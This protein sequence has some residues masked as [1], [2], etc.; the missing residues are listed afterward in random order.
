MS[1]LRI[2]GGRRLEGTL[3]VHGAKNSVLPI[4]A[5]SILA[6]GETIIHNCPDL[7][8]VNAAIKILRHLGCSVDKSNDRVIINSAQMTRS[9]IPHELMK[10]MR[11][12]VIFLGAILARCGTAA[13]SMPGGCE[14]GPR[15]VD[16][17]MM[18][19]REMGAKITDEGGS[20]LC[21]A[22]ELLGCRINFPIPSVG[23]TENAML[24]AT[25]CQGTTI[26]TNAACEPE[27]WDIQRYLRTIGVKVT[28]AGT[29]TI[30]VEGGEI[31]ANT[32]HHVIP[33][34]IV[35]ATYLSCAAASSG[36]I[37][38][39]NVIPRHITTVTNALSEMGCRLKIYEDAIGIDATGKLTAI[40]PV[41]TRPYPGFPTD[42]Q[43]P[44]MAA[45]LKAS[46]TTVFI[47]SIFENRYRH[48][49]ELLRMGADIKT[50]GKVAM[51]TGVSKLF[52]VPVESTD[53][54]G[55]AALCV[56]ALGAEGITDVSGLHH[57]DRGYDGFEAALAAIGADIV[58][59]D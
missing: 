7:A 14:L 59:V 42:A 49:G 11:S 6:R 32:E 46:G 3:R 8:D 10:E 15:P 31:S 30:I 5:A 1:I 12:S 38:I 27:I 20:I 58:R 25:A 57:I 44:L 50:E 43:P 33:D 41:I 55:G 29:S 37:E 48:I 4:M 45:S 28:G 34:R 19:L 23:A 36:K 17:H 2:T 47:E 26:I 13:L 24:A 35:A 56:A 22:N 39:T 54:R 21:A 9:D 53:L 51:V 40:K 18:A 16:L 52:G